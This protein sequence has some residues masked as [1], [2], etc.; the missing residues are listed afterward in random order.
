VHHRAARLGRGAGRQPGRRGN[1]HHRS[2]ALIMGRDPGISG[3]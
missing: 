2:G 1:R 3:P